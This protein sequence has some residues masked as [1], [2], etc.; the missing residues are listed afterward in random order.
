MSKMKNE[1][2]CPK[3]F[4]KIH[5][6]NKQY[7][8]SNLA[9]WANCT[10][11]NNRVLIK[12]DKPVVK[13]KCNICNA[14]LKTV[15]CYNCGFEI[16]NDLFYTDNFPIAVIGAKAAGKTNYVAVL[17]D[18]LKGDVGRS[19]NCALKASGEGTISRYKTEFY[20]PIFRNKECPQ[21]NIA[22][23]VEPLIYT[24]MLGGEKKLFGSTAPKSIMLTFFDTAGENLDSKTMLQSHNRYISFSSGIILLLDPLQLPGVR[25][26]L[27]GKINLPAE[28]TDPVEIITRITDI[29]REGNNIREGYINIPL[30]VVFTKI[31]AVSTLLDPSSSLH[32]NS[33]HIQ[34]GAFD[35]K[36]FNDINTEIQSL[37]D[38]WAGKELHNTINKNYNNYGYFGLSALGSNPVDNKITK[39]RP[40]RVTDPF[41]WLLSI[42][43]IIKTI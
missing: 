25:E 2:L 27:T 23:E 22:G 3:C 1:C 15:I 42:N 29:I 26:Q 28:H 43:K 32:N 7:I 13:P 24:L 8:C 34:K 36:D 11:A 33:I 35:K 16:P 10:N 12:L 38:E 30:A 9:Q 37:V 20:N 4:S 21:G 18:Q 5:S 31:D 41:L 40:F 19:F 6:G 39:F 17:I 14:E